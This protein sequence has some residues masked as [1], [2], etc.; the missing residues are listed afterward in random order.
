[1]DTTISKQILDSLKTE[2]YRLKKDNKRLVYENRLLLK[3]NSIDTTYPKKDSTVISYFT[4]EKTLLKR[5]IKKYR[6]PDCEAFEIEEFFNDQELP[7]YIEYWTCDCRKK[8]EVAKDEIVF[9]KLLSRYERFVYDSMGRVVTRIF[10]YS[11]SMPGPRR[12]E[13][14]Y[15]IDG[16][17]TT[18]MKRISENQFWD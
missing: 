11:G 9:E 10:I 13:Y 7:E 16:K 1:M 2:N 15:D 12:F 18:Q 14:K 5:I 4:K 8:N 17:A 6:S 3:G